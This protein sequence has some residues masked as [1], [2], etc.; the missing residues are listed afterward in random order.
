MTERV[1]S[2]VDALA[3]LLPH[4]A[5]GMLTALGVDAVEVA[6]FERDYELAG[7]DFLS[8]CFSET[9]LAYCAGDVGKLAARFALKEAA[10]KALGTGI[11]GIGLHDIEIET[12]PSGGPTL[13][14]S[15]AA[16]AV[17]AAGKLGP[18]RCSITR[19]SGLALAVVAAGAQT[20]KN[21]SPHDQSHRSA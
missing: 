20:S 15:P 2:V 7:D 6:E 19:E 10:L 17:A 5:S 13:R 18:L 12:A 8:Q 1:D 3:T 9:E 21:R 11:R 16:E 14:L 4:A